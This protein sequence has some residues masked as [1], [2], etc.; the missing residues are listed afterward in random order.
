MLHSWN[1]SATGGN[2]VRDSTGKPVGGSEERNRDTIP[3]ETNSND[4]GGL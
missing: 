1:Q 2:P 3:P 4:F